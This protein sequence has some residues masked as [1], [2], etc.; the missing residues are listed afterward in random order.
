MTGGISMYFTYSI[1]T[2]G[3]ARVN[4]VS[5]LSGAPGALIAFGAWLITMVTVLGVNDWLYRRYPLTTG[6]NDATAS[7]DEST[8]EA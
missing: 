1:A 5:T 6:S 3:I 2:F 4:G 8:I 7:N